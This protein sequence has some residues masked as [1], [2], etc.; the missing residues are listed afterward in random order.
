MIPAPA[1]DARP[2]PGRR[3]W[4]SIAG[5]VIG[6]ALLLG[7]IAAVASRWETLRQQWDSGGGGDRWESGRWGLLAAAV[8]LP[9]VNWLL[10]SASFWVLTRR[11]G[12][13]G[14]GEMG[15]L[16]ATASLLN[17]LPLRP[18]LLGRVAYHRAV[19]GIPVWASLKV[20]IAAIVCSGVA[21]GVLLGATATAGPAASGLVATVAVAAPGIALAGVW[22]MAWTKEQSWSCY[23]G[24]AFLR[25]LDMMAW[26]GRYAVA[27]ALWGAPIGLGA[28]AVLAAVSQ[29]VTL[30]PLAGN[31]LGLREWGTGYTTAW[32][33]AVGVVAT[34][35]AGARD[36]G[37][38]ADLVNRAGELV[39]LVPIGI[40]GWLWVVRRLARFG[41]EGAA[42]APGGDNPTPAERPGEIG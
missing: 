16:I 5:F 22:G 6:V 42:V 24:A 25:Y 18:G 7:A 23:A 8:A 17:Y 13:I 30:V 37:L 35:G 20:L 41:L 14:P 36:L 21:A 26:T 19:N 28:A 4:V 38:A 1:A 29:A 2:E 40:L 11:Y 15:A 32:L 27:F 33:S 39:A 9:V 10:T 12:R 31:G 34:G 3:R